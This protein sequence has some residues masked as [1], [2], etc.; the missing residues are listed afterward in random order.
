MAF[1][2]AR[3]LRLRM[4]YL[5]SAGQHTRVVPSRT[6]G[7]YAGIKRRGGGRGRN[8]LYFLHERDV[9]NELEVRSR[10]AFGERFEQAHP[11][12][13]LS[14]GVTAPIGALPAAR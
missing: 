12:R 3:E 1:V 11:E 6:A 10:R 7:Y 5:S 8:V 4:H 13:A 9:K 2:R 14:V